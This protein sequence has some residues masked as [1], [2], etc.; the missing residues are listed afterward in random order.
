VAGDI[1]RGLTTVTVKVRNPEIT[2][3]VKVQDFQNWL[4]RGCKSPIERRFVVIAEESDRIPFEIAAQ[5]LRPGIVFNSEPEE[6]HLSDDLADLAFQ[7]TFARSHVALRSIA[8]PP[9]WIVIAVPRDQRRADYQ[10]EDRAPVI[11]GACGW[12]AFVLGQ[13]SP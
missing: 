1:G 10:P 9:S 2:H 6:R 11:A 8:S 7:G 13:A 5:A 4:N 12:R 3:I